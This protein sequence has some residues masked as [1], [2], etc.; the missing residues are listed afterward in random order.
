MS[1][2]AKLR[3]DL[4]YPVIDAD[5]HWLEYSPVVLEAMRKIGRDV[6]TKA[7]RMGGGRVR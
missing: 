4:G 1:K 5:G 2:A 7:I 3:A 6:A